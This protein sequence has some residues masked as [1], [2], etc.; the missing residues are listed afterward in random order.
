[1]DTMSA[2]ELIGKVGEIT[3]VDDLPNGQFNYCVSCN[4]RLTDAN[5]GHFSYHYMHEQEL[6]PLAPSEFVI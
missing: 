2:R 4:G 6:E 5:A 1:M 3:E